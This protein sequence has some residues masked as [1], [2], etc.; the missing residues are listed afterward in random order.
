M[1]GFVLGITHTLVN[2]PANAAIEPDS[3][4]SLSSLPGSL[5]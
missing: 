5:K 1:G 4:V 2:P 3:K